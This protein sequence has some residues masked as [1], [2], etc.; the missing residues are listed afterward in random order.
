[1]KIKCH[2]C[3]GLGETHEVTLPPDNP[4]EWWEDCRECNK[5]GLIEISLFDYIWDSV[6]T[7]IFKIKCIPYRLSY[8]NH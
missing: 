2:M 3:N 5:T 4:E 7:I 8:K 1:M 6:Q